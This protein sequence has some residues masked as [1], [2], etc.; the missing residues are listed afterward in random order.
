MKDKRE[1]WTYTGTAYWNS[2]VEQTTLKVH[3]RFGI[4][5]RLISRLIIKGITVIKKDD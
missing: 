1:M 3:C 5:G 4:I 2:E